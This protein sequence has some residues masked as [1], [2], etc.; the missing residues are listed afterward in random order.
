MSDEKENISKGDANFSKGLEK[1]IRESMAM[2]DQPIPPDEF[3]K[4]IC[5]YATNSITI[6]LDS[7]VSILNVSKKY[8][9][10]EEGEKDE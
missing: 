3:I 7:V 1:L 8:E 6:F 4:C 2:S 10:K 9:Q 5:D